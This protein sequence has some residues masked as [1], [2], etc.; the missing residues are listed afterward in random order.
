MYEATNNFEYFR[1]SPDRRYIPIDCQYHTSFVLRFINSAHKPECIFPE[2]MALLCL[3]AI[4]PH[5]LDCG[6][7]G[8]WSRSDKPETDD[9]NPSIPCSIY[10][11]RAKFAGKILALHVRAVIWSC[12]VYVMSHFEGYDMECGHLEMGN[13]NIYIRTQY[14]VKIFTKRWLL[15]HSTWIFKIRFTDM[16]ICR[17]S[18]YTIISSLSSV[19]MQLFN[20]ELTGIN[21]P[22]EASIKPLLSTHIVSLLR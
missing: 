2:K 16:Q 21:Q 4:E 7:I 1:N 5:E 13:G 20:T 11:L 12:G 22:V 8:C 14:P 10:L 19:K 15:A 6:H 9:R 3:S 17:H 18:L